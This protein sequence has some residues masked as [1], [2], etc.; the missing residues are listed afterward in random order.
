MGENGETGLS[1]LIEGDREI[2]LETAPIN[3]VHIVGC[4]LVET[5]I[6]LGGRIDFDFGLD[7]IVANAPF[8]HMHVQVLID[9]RT[10][11]VPGYVWTW[12][13][14][15]HAQKCNLVAQHVLEIEVRGLQDLGPLV[16]QNSQH[17]F[18]TLISW[19]QLTLLL[20]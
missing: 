5:C 14:L 2:G 16:K 10:V 7:S 8:M 6:H 3:R 13:A 17:I 19:V 18:H 11:L 4:A 1:P 15:G 9:F 20:L 12:V